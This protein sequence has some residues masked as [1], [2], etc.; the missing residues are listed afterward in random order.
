MNKSFL[1]LCLSLPVFFA[2][3][4]I[5]D[6]HF[7]DVIYGD[8]YEN[9][10]KVFGTTFSTDWNTLNSGEV[11]VYVDADLEGIQK[12]L[13]L[14]LP[15]FGGN[16]DAVILSETEA[17]YGDVVTLAYEAPIH[18]SRMYATLLMAD[19]TYYIKG[20]NV[21]QQNVS[22]QEDVD[23][24]ANA[25]RAWKK[26]TED[27]TYTLQRSYMTY[28]KERCLQGL[29]GYDGW[30]ND[31]LYALSDDEEK[32][33]EIVGVPDYSAD[34]K[35]DLRACIF[36]FLPQ[37]ED[38]LPSIK[39]SGYYNDACYLTTNG[40][41]PVIVYLVH[42]NDGGSNEVGSSHLNY[43]YYK[44]SDIEGMTEAEQI[45]YFKS[46]P[47]YKAVQM[48]RTSS[49]LPNDSIQKQRGYHLIYWGDERVPELYNSRKPT[50]TYTKGTYNFP[51]GYKI[52]FMVG[53][54]HG[55]E[56]KR[57]ELYCDGRLNKG[58]NSYGDY[59]SSGFDDNDPRMAW[60]ECNR[61]QYLCIEIG[62]DRDYNDVVFEIG[63]GVESLNDTLDAEYAGYMFC[64]ENT[65]LGD[66]DMN[67]V[68]IRAR[69]ISSRKVEYAVLACGASD[70]LYIQNIDGKRIN[71]NTEVHELFGMK[72]RGF[73]NTVQHSKKYAYVLDTIDVAWDYS[74]IKNAPIVFNK[75]KNLLVTLSKEGQDPHAI[76]IPY[77]FKW[78]LERVCIKDAYLNFV[79]WAKGVEGTDDWYVNPTDSKVFER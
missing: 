54:W 19:G 24:A 9:E 65:R 56:S 25:R 27:I 3:G 52:G 36:S 48:Y 74:I 15:P 30:E 41:E 7:D 75:T 11:T 45:Q 78:P 17:Q 79:D 55:I 14:T 32:I 6:Y 61:K 18:C 59:A 44:E 5:E 73:I 57:G 28:S 62:V 34:F 46:L 16:K 29:Y 68:V 53:C 51:A 50:S 76:M 42:R 66:Y 63:S 49:Y 60:M 1:V 2:C 71:K 23:E 39:K 22:F 77:D 12:V 31:S 37:K 47:K 64:Y 72:G 26:A 38:N 13:I 33:A 58:I 20:F 43:Y 70:E 8:V 10:E 67:D 40:K 4:N 69:R 35:E 21:G